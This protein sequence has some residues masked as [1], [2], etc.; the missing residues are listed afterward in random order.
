MYAV[1][2]WASHALREASPHVPTLWATFDTRG[3][4]LEAGDT[5]PFPIVDVRDIGREGDCPGRRGNA[6]PL[7]HRFERIGENEHRE[8]IWRCAS[9]GAYQDEVYHGGTLIGRPAD[10]RLL[11]SWGERGPL[12]R[13]EYEADGH[14]CSLHR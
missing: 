8:G 4:A 14:D 3:A 11:P 6:V 7:G 5:V 10:N 1:R 13:E 9:C 12:T 2:T